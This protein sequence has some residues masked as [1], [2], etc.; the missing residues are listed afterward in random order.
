MNYSRV[1]LV[2]SCC[3]V[4]G[5]SVGFGAAR[6][7]PS[8]HALVVPNV[9]RDD[10]VAY[11]TWRG[12]DGDLGGSIGMRMAIADHC[13]TARTRIACM[14]DHYSLLVIDAENGDRDG[15]VATATALMGSRHCWD[16]RRARFWLAKAHSLGAD[17]SGPSKLLADASKSSGCRTMVV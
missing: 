6:F 8:D 4:I 14:R 5:A 17:I 7:M 16:L 9:P 2:A 11:L 3:L 15:M 1:W 13:A 12:V 10:L